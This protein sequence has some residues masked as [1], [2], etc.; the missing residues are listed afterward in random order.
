MGQNHNIMSIRLEEFEGV[1]LVVSALFVLVCLLTTFL[2]LYSV[3]VF[4]L[5][6]LYGKTGLG[7]DN[8]DGCATFLKET[9][10][11]REWGFYNFLVSLVGASEIKIAIHELHLAEWLKL[12]I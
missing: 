6:S 1:P 10:R 4:A 8:Y 12:L 9:A 7:I 5:C 3:T 11:Y 2:S